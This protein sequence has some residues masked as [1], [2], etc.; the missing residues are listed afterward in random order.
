MNQ[1]APVMQA[2]PARETHREQPGPLAVLVACGWLDAAATVDP[3]VRVQTLSRSHRVFR[4]VTPEGRSAIVK[5]QGP[6]ALQMGRSLSRELYIYRLTRWLPELA[7]VLAPP[8]FIDERQQLLVLES[9][10]SAEHWPNG[11]GVSIRTP[12]VAAQLGRSMAIWQR[13]TASVP[14]GPSLAE[15]ILYLPEALDTALAGRSASGQHFLRG[16]AADRVLAAALTAARDCYR[17]VCL[18]HGDLRCDNWLLDSGSPT[19]T[20]RMIDWELSGTGDPVWDLASAFAE[21]ILDLLRSS[22]AVDWSDRGW[23]QSIVGVLAE[24]V[25]GYTGHGGAFDAEGADLDRL[26]LFV[27]ARLMH[28][29]SEWAEQQLDPDGPAPASVLAQA[30]TLLECRR[31]AAQALRE[32]TAQG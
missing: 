20:L 24:I 16:V 12:T 21:A 17:H 11:D 25:K 14:F 5:Q 19:P 31:P 30:R 9:L 1:H 10:S 32:W 22:E 4:V 13:S 29:G 2:L 7:R 15:G 8:L 6:A 23:P 18:I 27:A 28:V 26:I 3:G